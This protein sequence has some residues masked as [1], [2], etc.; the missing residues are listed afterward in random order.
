MLPPNS[1]AVP[2]YGDDH[3]MFAATYAFFAA[4]DTLPARGL[5]DTGT[6]SAADCYSVYLAY[7]CCVHDCTQASGNTTAQ[8]GHRVQGRLLVDLGYT[9]FMYHSVL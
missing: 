2:L 1:L 6:N 7:L 5:A 8:E 3:L 9:N 4:T